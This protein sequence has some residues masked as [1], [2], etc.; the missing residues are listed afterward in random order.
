MNSW[1]NCGELE[2]LYAMR[3]ATRPPTATV[4]DIKDHMEKCL[5]CR[6]NMELMNSKHREDG[7]ETQNEGATTGPGSLAGV[8]ALQTADVGSG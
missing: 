4:D 7:N 1:V 6:G 5:L 3:Y 2:M 8:P